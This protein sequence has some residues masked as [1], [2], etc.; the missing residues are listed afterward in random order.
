MVLRPC[1]S[2]LHQLQT[3]PL[4]NFEAAQ[5]PDKRPESR[6]VRAVDRE[7][8]DIRKMY[9]GMCLRAHMCG[10]FSPHFLCRSAAPS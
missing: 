9:V 5:V 6:E 10:G 8:D 4:K 2:C 1:I 7:R 3:H